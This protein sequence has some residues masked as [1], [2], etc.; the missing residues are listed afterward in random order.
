[1][2]HHNT[3]WYPNLRLFRQ[4]VRG[5]WSGLFVEIR[6]ALDKHLKQV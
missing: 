5:D 4:G 2:D 6:A 3:P 1:V